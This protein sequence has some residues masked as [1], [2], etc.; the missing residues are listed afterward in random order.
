MAIAHEGRTTSMVEQQTAK[1]PSL[2][3][4]G[5][6]VGAMAASAAL[7]FTGR[8]QLAN[9]VGQWAPSI[10]IVGLYNKVAKELAI[11]RATGYGTA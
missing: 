11:P 7:L 5:I 8:K 2:A 1:V 9:F 6:A 3:Y 10:L 4:M